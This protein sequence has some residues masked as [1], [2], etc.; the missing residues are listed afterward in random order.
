MV[1]EF[2]SIECFPNI[3]IGNNGTI[4]TKEYIDKSGNK[5][6]SKI[7]KTFDHNGYTR[8]R[9]TIENGQKV[10]GVHRLVA[11]A[12]VKNNNN[13]PEVNHIDENKS[14]NYYKNLEW[15]THKENSNHGTR[16]ERIGKKTSER[17]N[18]NGRLFKVWNENEYYEF[19]NMRECS[20][21][22]NIKYS[23]V[24]RKLKNMSA[25]C[26]YNFKYLE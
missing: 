6:K 5:R 13:Y 18:K 15:V 9:I 20:R 12:F 17:Y 7:L 19:R 14:N 1:E 21:V 2:K 8:V 10:I 22:L 16:G 11:L 23:S 4:K 24:Y 3:L 26:D 25:N